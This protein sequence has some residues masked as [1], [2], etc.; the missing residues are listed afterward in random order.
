MLIWNLGEMGSMDDAFFFFFLMGKG[1]HGF[2]RTEKYQVTIST[3]KNGGAGDAPKD[4]SEK[5]SF[6]MF[7]L[8]NRESQ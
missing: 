5:C 8:D 6:E 7:E 2:E 3:L 1:Q 4:P